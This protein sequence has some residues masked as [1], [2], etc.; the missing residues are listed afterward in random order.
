[1]FL[2]KVAALLLVCVVATYPHLA[3]GNT[4]TEKHKEA[5]LEQCKEF[6]RHGP[7][8]HPFPRE[9]HGACCKAARDVPQMNMHCVIKLLTPRE[10][11]EYSEDKVVQL[12]HFCQMRQ[13]Q[14]GRITNSLCAIEI[15][16]AGNILSLFMLRANTLSILFH[17]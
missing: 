9:L 4:C 13:Q 11:K 14:H 2:Q 10:E 6:I 17:A 12:K 1:M 5:I 16:S 15:F 3:M 8:P 7:P